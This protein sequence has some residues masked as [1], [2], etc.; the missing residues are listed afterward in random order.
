MVRMPLNIKHHFDRT[1]PPITPPPPPPSHLLPPPPSPNAET[2]DNSWLKNIAKTSAEHQRVLHCSRVNPGLRIIFS[3]TRSVYIK[4]KHMR[5]GAGVPGA[6]SCSD[7]C[8]GKR[9]V[10]QKTHLAF[11]LRCSDHELILLHPTSN[12][13]VSHQHDIST[14]KTHGT[15]PLP[16]LEL[17]HRKRT[18]YHSYLLPMNSSY[19]A[20]SFTNMFYDPEGC[21]S[22]V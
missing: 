2:D 11:F 16:S 20:L 14:P 22:S 15:I 18:Q 10:T 8:C 21:T 4:K 1:L 13:T 9:Y 7:L 3:H 19:R 6:R 12:E 5:A 17:Y